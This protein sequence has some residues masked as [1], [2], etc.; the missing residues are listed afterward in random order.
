MGNSMRIMT[1]NVRVGV[2]SSFADLAAAIQAVGVPDVLALQEIGVRWNMG[3][4]IDQPAWLACALGLPSHAFGGALTDAKGGQ[5]GVALCTRWP[6][7]A[8]TIEPLPQ[9]S[10]EQR[11]L[12][13]ARMLGPTPTHLFCT[14]LSVNTDER[15][16]QAQVVGARV[17]ATSGP[18]LVLGDLNDRPDTP[19]VDA[20]RGDLLDLFDA[21]GVGPAVTFSVVDPHR[22]IDYLFAR[23]FRP[24]GAA[25]VARE[26]TASDHFPVVCDVV[27]DP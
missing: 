6:L 23:G 10:D 20:A 26:A 3:E 24:R 9:G 15:L 14:H 1:Y 13:S 16:L 21:A 11:V 27:P 7:E 12:L 25:R 5:F 8:V 22:R 17:L 2:E 18:A 4:H 19:T